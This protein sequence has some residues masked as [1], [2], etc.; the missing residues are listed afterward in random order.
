MTPLAPA[1]LRWHGDQPYSLQFA[2]IYHAPDGPAE[3]ERVFVTPNRLAERFAA[4]RSETFRVGEIGFGTGLNFV[5]VAERFL[6]HAPANMRLHFV[7]FEAHPLDAAAFAVLAE[8]RRHTGRAYRELATAYP[9]LL[10][11]WHRRRFCGGRVQLS[12]YFGDALAGLDDIAARQRQP[13]DAWLLDGFAPARNPDAW[14]SGL[15]AR[16]TGLSGA[17][18]T[19]ATFTSAGDVRRGLEEAGFAMT[20]IDQRPHKRHSLCGVFAGGGLERAPVPRVVTVVGCGLAGGATARELAEAG[21]DVRL[22]ERAEGPRN[23]LAGAVL[24]ARLVDPDASGATRRALAYAHSTA[25]LRGFAGVDQSGVLQFATER[26]PAA[27]LERLAHAFAETGRWL[28]RVGPATASAIAGVP[29]TES[30][31]HFRDGGTVDLPVLCAALR[32]HPRILPI[33][34]VGSDA[35][36]GPRDEATVLCVGPDV[37]EFPGA[38][39]LE[40]RPVWGQIDTMA[41]GSRAAVPLVGDGFVSPLAGDLCAVGATYEHRP[42]DAARATDF[43]TARGRRFLTRIAPGSF[44]SMRAGHSM[45]GVRAVTSDRVPIIGRLDAPDRVAPCWLNLGHGSQ[46]TVTA[47]LGA[48]CIAAMLAGDFAP[49]TTVELAGLAPD[50]F[51]ARQRRRGLRHGAVATRTRA[52]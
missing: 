13:I 28:S 8:R 48:V 12:L 31:L 5:L 7:S 37:G 19:V 51:I 18:S 25:W 32:D 14:S 4:A 16:V 15:F 9:P 50:R 26:F 24:H 45:R 47:P 49:L 36:D 2:D 30:A 6:A 23:R 35:L 17:G 42:W 10:A 1:R 39:F 46:G 34:E 44:L 11:G 22:A 52:R 33:G 29:I 27:R 38:G 41:T 43:N 3:V 21:F 40:V 20:R